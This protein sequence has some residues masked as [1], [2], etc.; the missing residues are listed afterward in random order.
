MFV[1]RSKTM[2]LFGR[3]VDRLLGQVACALPAIAFVHAGA[4]ISVGFALFLGFIAAW[5]RFWAPGTAVSLAIEPEGLEIESMS[6]FRLVPWAA[7]SAIQT[8]HH[9][10]RIDCVAVHYRS[11]GR[12]AVASC[13]DYYRE[14]ELAAFVRACADHVCAVTP[15]ESLITVA[16]LCDRSVWLPLL[17]RLTQDVVVASL[18]GVAL[19][20]VGPACLL[21]LIVA[22]QSAS[23][24]A[25]RH[26]FRAR[27][28]VQAE[29]LWREQA[30]EARPLRK[31]P[32]SLRLWILCLGEAEYSASVPHL[33]DAS[34]RS[35]TA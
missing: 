26:P 2:A 14:D 1:L 4:A 23:V 19:G 35:L 10:N 27:T 29:G 20:A 31:L 30:R 17:R 24:A 33:A 13:R 28:L 7:V 12:I 8:W 34:R 5:F 18:I 21:G 11:A 32:R 9:Y 25:I 15:C 6:G 16:G 22:A 3:V